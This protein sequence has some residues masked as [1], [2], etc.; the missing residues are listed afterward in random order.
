MIVAVFRPFGA[1][2]FFNTPINEFHDKS[3]SLD[4]LGDKGLVEL[5]KRILNEPDDKVCISLIERFF[6]KR[7][8]SVNDYNYYRMVAS[9]N[10]INRSPSIAIKSLADITCLSYKQFNRIFTGY[11]GSNP[12]E[13]IRIVRFQLALFILQNNADISMTSL[14]YECGYYDQPHLVKEFKTFSG[15]T[16]TEYIAICAPYSDYFSQS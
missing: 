11:I 4:D 10:A 15:Y 2:I 8:S 16:P 12:K 1:K 6:I 3:I 5:K 13:F 7:L 9:I 14:A